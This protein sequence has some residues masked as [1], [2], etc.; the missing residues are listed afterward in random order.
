VH[1]VFTTVEI[2]LV[3][4]PSFIKAALTTF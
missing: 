4:L 2:T 1:K 3:K